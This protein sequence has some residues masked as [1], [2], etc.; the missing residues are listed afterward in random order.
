MRR[1][2]AVESESD[3]R[4][5]EQHLRWS[6]DKAKS[7][8]SSD[9]CEYAVAQR[10]HEPAISRLLVLRATRSNRELVP[11]FEATFRTA[12]PADP[13]AVRRSLM[14]ADAPWP[15]AGMLWAAVEGDSVR[16]LDRAP[17]GLGRRSRGD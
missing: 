12:Y 17:P 7:L 6:Q 3:I 9:I 2:V 5:V 1:V 11:D 8:P 10:G 4:R 16:I 13:A 14:T 15:G